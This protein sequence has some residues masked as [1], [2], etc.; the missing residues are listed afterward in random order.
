MVGVLV[1]LASLGLGVR[2]LDVL[3]EPHLHKGLRVKRADYSSFGGPPTTSS[4]MLPS[5]PTNLRKPSYW[6]AQPPQRYSHAKRRHKVW[7]AFMGAQHILS[8]PSTTINHTI[9]R[10][11]S[12]FRMM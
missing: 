5:R 6:V 7:D 3:V 11:K 1:L 9:G 8:E 10:R 4:A 12:S 2:L